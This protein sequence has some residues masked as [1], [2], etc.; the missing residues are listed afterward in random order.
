MRFA[1]TVVCATVSRPFFLN[2]AAAP[3]ERRVIRLEPSRSLPE[4]T[5]TTNGAPARGARILT[6]IAIAVASGL[7]AYFAARRQ[8]AVP[9][10]LY[11]W[12]GARLFLSGVDPYAAMGGHRGAAPPYD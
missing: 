6:A 11:P 8:G 4:I 5:K 9:D 10:F 2:V 3:I 12:T 1:H 7:V